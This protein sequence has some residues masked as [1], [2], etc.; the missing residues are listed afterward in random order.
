M[1]ATTR[2]LILALAACGL[3]WA[4]SACAG[5]AGQMVSRVP[6]G[7]LGPPTQ[8]FAEGMEFSQQPRWDVDLSAEP[9]VLYISNYGSSSCPPRVDSLSVVEPGVLEVEVG[10]S[11]LLGVC[12]ADLGGPYITRLELPA[13]ALD[14]ETLMVRGYA[15]DYALPIP[16][17]NRR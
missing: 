15:E 12:T 9:A 1:P 6:A 2:N 11:S 7:A 4:V 17:A 10:S 3:A 13:G 16:A 14:A 5:P 8:I